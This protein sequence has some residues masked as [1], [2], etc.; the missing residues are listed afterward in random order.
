MITNWIKQSDNKILLLVL[1][2]FFL[3]IFSLI[4]GG[5]EFSRYTEP[6]VLIA[7]LGLFMYKYPKI[8]ILLKGFILFAL[9]GNVFGL[10]RFEVE[11]IQLETIAYCLGYLCLLYE[12]VFKIKKVK[13]NYIV[14]LYL[15]FVFAINAYF[16]YVLYEIFKEVVLNNLELSLIVVR[17]VSLL[18]FA[19]FSF[20]LYLSSETKQSILLL[21]M[22]I[23]L[24]FSDVLFLIDE[25]YLYFWIFDF[26]SKSLYLVTIYC[27]YLYISGFYKNKTTLNLKEVVS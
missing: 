13:I 14:G 15:I 3:K 9:A 24:I 12:A 4:T 26:L 6:W 27:L 7:I 19:L 16:I 20:T 17:L 2:L 22:S 23:S 10:F 5:Q 21:I 1:L 11:G 8:S 25:Y 18:L